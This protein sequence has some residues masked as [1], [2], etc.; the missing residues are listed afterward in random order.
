VQAEHFEVGRD[1]TAV[2]TAR[3]AAVRALAGRVP[4]DVVDA[5]EL[6]VSEL[7]GNA[8]LHGAPPVSL[9][10]G[11]GSSPDSARIEVHDASRTLPVRARA[12][13][14]GNEG[15]TGRGLGLIDAVAQRW[16]VEATGGGKA[17]WAELTP[18]SVAA[19]EPGAGID[20]DGL[21]AGYEEW[22]D[23]DG[24]QRYTVRL[25]GVPTDLLLAAK[26]HVDSVV[27]ELA[28]SASGAES[29]VSAELAPH[30]ADLVRDVTF[31]WAEV[32]QS[33]KR[34]AVTAAERGEQRTSLTLTLPLSAAE[35]GERYLAALEQ[36]DTYGRSSR[37]LTAAAP[38]QHRA[39]HRWY[40]TSLVD[41]LRRA[42]AGETDVVP[43]SFETHLLRE[44]DHLAT[45]QQVS[46]R[47]ARLQRASASLSGALRPAAVA[48]TVLAESIADLGA[49]RGVLLLPSGGD[50]DLGRSAA[51][52]GYSPEL[53]AATAAAW[54][55]GRS[56]PVTQAWTT[57]TAVWVE[58]RP[59]DE[60]P[61]FARLEP[62]A[63]AACAVPL[64]VGGALVGVLSLTFLDSRLFT[65]DERAFLRALAAVGAQA[66]ERAHLHE[67]QAE[68]AERLTRLQAVT[69][70]LAG[71]T[72][73]DEVLDVTI[74]HATGLVGAWRAS[75]CLLGDD[76][77]TVE[78]HRVVPPLGA[79]QS[80]WAAFDL[81]AP[82]PASEA[83][84]TGEIVFA[85]TL[86]DR[87]ARWPSIAHFARD[88][89]HS[90]VVLPLHGDAGPFGAV[91]L[92]FTAGGGAT[93]DLALLRA[94]ADA[95][96][97]AVQRT[98]ADERARSANLRLAFLARASG[99]L[100]SSLDPEQTLRGIA[101]LS[102]PEIADWCVVHLL[103]DG[104]LRALAVEHVDATRTSLAWE[105]QRRWPSR[106]SDR[107]GV[108]QVVR[109][110]DPQLIPDIPTL[111]AELE[112]AGVPLPQRDPEHQALLD[113]LG[114]RSAMI[115]PLEARGRTLG[116]LTFITAES[117]RVYDDDDL[118]FALDLA[119]RA[120]VAL[121]NAR[122]FSAATD[123]AVHD[124]PDP[125]GD[126]V[127]AVLEA[128]EV[129]RFSVHL[130]DGRLE[131]DERLAS[132]FGFDERDKA[133]HL[134]GFLARIHPDDLAAVRGMMEDAAAEVRD[135]SIEHRVVLPSGAVRWIAV[136]GS[137]L[138]DASGAA[139]RLVGVA[140][141][142]TTARDV[143]DR[144]ARLLETMADAFFRL[145]RDWRFSYVNSQAE[146][147]LFRGREELL[148][149][150]LWTEFPEALGSEFETHYRGAVLSGR[151]V[152]FEASFAPLGAWFEVRAT[153]DSEGLSV[154]FHD[155]TV[156][157][158]AEQAREA[159]AERLA[160]LA[161]ATRELVGALEAGEVLGRIVNVLVP[162]LGEWAVTA[163]LDGE[164]RL[165]RARAVHADPGLTARIDAL[166]SERPHVLESVPRVARVLATGVG[167][168]SPSHPPPPEGV[169]PDLAELVALVGYGSAMV[170]PLASGSTVL[171]VICVLSGADQEPFSA[172]D[173]ASAADIGRR[174]GLALQNAQL[175]E[176]QRTAVEV[177]QRSMLTAL[178]QPESLEL[179]AR[180]RPGGAGGPGRRRLVRRLPAAGRR[181]GAG[182]RRRDRARHRGRGGDGPAAQPAARHGLRPAGEPRARPDPRRRRPARPADRHARDRPGG[183]ARA[184]AGAADHRHPDGALVERR[185]PA[186]RAAL[187]RRE[188]AAAGGRRRPAARAGR[189]GGAPRPRPGDACG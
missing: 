45:L 15:L 2:P 168:L 174:A 107:Q 103:Q 139:D 41:G 39:F 110:G 130:A 104:D 169:D 28:L 128:A 42:A 96:A 78:M 132:F 101:R 1:A 24:V 20:L 148:G 127:E 55:E 137:A 54:R 71:A 115:V 160:L 151:P 129:G 30:L 18:A 142:T 161:D 16:G 58:A 143:R 119:R 67:R 65:D 95:C 112:R 106:L 13:V 152:T 8:L 181:H 171:G 99:E 81:A 118:A 35:A 86:A 44:I 29:G 57:A 73:L 165:S 32:R 182:H 17:V 64:H 120:A 176:R 56:T 185:P 97:Q 60:H 43:P 22:P 87:N 133:G 93:P 158:Q 83:I 144:T 34:Q 11:P 109:S 61:E 113:G 59:Q 19:A 157:K 10:V 74:E 170:V 31:E 124:L 66:L 131:S 7:T 159:A 135:Y 180:Y 141:D 123:R 38:P 46:E 149:H 116:A 62:D 188:P 163:L 186:R 153:P 189:H 173:L 51:S 134:E 126:S 114:L 154:F 90:L 178:P 26:A 167:E 108:A 147:L 105:V 155:V 100:A 6:V 76:G 12:A 94:Y 136:R 184:V 5:V 122:L 88:I 91:G 14:R 23:P 79:D 145:D 50:D 49:L 36:A 33:I 40:V 68:V 156:R 150:S 102:V 89:E 138:P 162:A 140:Y 75:L 92:S 121:D 77:R 27:R 47:S 125:A 183:P 37:L 63:A 48:E 84:R 146:K 85:P 25:D 53:L 52:T 177:L 4:D 80:G 175:F 166:L 111:T 3:R 69:S 70:A 164:G 9:V 187:S 72:S 179:V 172:D 117:G 82:V 21:L 98:R